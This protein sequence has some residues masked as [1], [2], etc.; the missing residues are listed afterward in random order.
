MFF[1]FFFSFLGL[2]WGTFILN[3]AVKI[4]DCE[5]RFRRMHGLVRPGFRLR[6]SRDGLL[7]DG[8]IGWLERLNETGWSR[9]L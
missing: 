1:F 6:C 8:G 7:E 4:F 3:A 9:Q 5:C 2:K